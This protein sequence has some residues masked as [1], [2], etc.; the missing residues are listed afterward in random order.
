MPA[1]KLDIVWKMNPDNDIMTLCGSPR[2][3]ISAKINFLHSDLCLRVACHKV[4]YAQ[5]AAQKQGLA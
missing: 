1:K 5:R 3:E 2:M 4:A